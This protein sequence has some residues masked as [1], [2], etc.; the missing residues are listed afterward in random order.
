MKISPIIDDDNENQMKNGDEVKCGDGDEMKNE[1]IIMMAMICF[2]E[3]M[4]ARVMK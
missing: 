3:C 1:M 2:N 4:R